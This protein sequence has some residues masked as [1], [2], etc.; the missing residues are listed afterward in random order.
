MQ[1]NVIAS[2]INPDM[3]YAADIQHQCDLKNFSASFAY[4]IAYRESI[5]LEVNGGTNAATVVSCDGGYGLFQLTYPFTQPWPPAGWQ[6]P[7]NN[8]KYALD[9]FLIPNFNMFAGRGLEGDDLVKVTAASY[10]AGAQA[11]WEAH[12]A[13]N[14]D[15]VTTDNYGEAVLQ[16][17]LRLAQGLKPE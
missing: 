4:A 12:E 14:V 11:A 7:A 15:S 8:C 16:F 9:E 3:P 13:G 17:Y 10:N 6:I 5:R 2:R 1:F